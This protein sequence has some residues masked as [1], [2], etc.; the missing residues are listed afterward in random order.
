MRLRFITVTT[1]SQPHP[2]S[3]S[4]PPSSIIVPV[5]LEPQILEPLDPSLAKQALPVAFSL[6][7]DP[8][9]EFRVPRAGR[10]NI[11]VAIIGPKLGQLVELV[12]PTF[13]L[14]LSYRF[15][16]SIIN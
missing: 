12:C 14:W 13:G 4:V 3:L 10:G 5:K 7:T 6:V 11:A 8:F 9:A 1:S 2:E 16:W 15:H